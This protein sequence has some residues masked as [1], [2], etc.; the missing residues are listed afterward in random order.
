PCSAKLWYR[1]AAP[2]GIYKEMTSSEVGLDHSFLLTQTDFNSGAPYDFYLEAADQ[3]GNSVHYPTVASNGSDHFT[4]T[5]TGRN[6]STTGFTQLPFTLPSGYILNKTSVI[7]GKPTLV[8]NRYDTSG[9]FGKLMAYQYV[10]GAFNPVDSTQRQWVPRDLKDAFNDGR[11]STLVQ[12]QGVTELLSSNSGGSSFFVNK[13]FVDSADVWGSQLYDFDGDGKL[14]LI[15]RSSSQYLVFKNMGENTFQLMAQLADPTPPLTGETTNEFGPPRSL[16]GDFSGTGNAEIIFADY[17]GDM[18]MYR[19]VNKQTA[20][21]QF[22]L[23]WTDTTDL[24]ETSDYLAAGDF[25]GDGQLDFAIAGHSN[26]D[27]N[28]DRE[29]DPPTWTVRIFTHRPTDP[30]NSFSKVWEQIFYGVK[31]G[32]SYDNGI[33]SGKILGT[34]ADQL[35]LSLN[36]YLYVIQY[37]AAAQNFAPMWVHS[38]ASNSVLVSDFNGDGVPELGFNAD[39]KTRFFEQTSTTSKPQAPWGISATPLSARAV[40]LQ[41]NSVAPSAMHKVYRDTVSQPQNLLTSVVG[42]SFIDT[43]VVTGKTYWYAVSL[44]NPTESDHSSSVSTVPHNPAQIVSVTQ[45]GLSQVS[46]AMSL[47]VD[48]NRLAVAAIVV[49]DSLNPNSIAIHTPSNLLLTFAQP[50]ASDSHYVRI[51]NLFDIYGMD[52]DTTQRIP[53]YASLQATHTFYLESASFVTQS[54]IAIVFNDTLSSSALDVSNYHFS[55][56]VRTFALKDVKLDTVSRSKVLLSLADNEHLTPVGFKMD[57]TA[58][59]KIQNNMGEALNNGEGQSVSLVIDVNNLDNIIV[60]PDPLRFSNVDAGRNHLTF[61]NVPEYCRIDIFETNGRKVTTLEGSTRADGIDWNLMD[62][63]GRP[64][65]SGIYIFLATQLDANNNEVRTKLGKF[66][67]IR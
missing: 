39:G 37:N 40:E 44:V 32:F 30:I 66:A 48:Q 63:H 9:N 61:A 33:S 21:F 20:P 8:L 65:D 64:V 24:L 41:W 6:I 17:D 10:N 31:T 54:L 16:V 5:F 36:P 28:A 38:S 18:I 59:N 3:S 19:Q 34:S 47:P 11:L 4:F 14:D 29:Y 57:L 23:V 42:T 15:A 35:L 27:L 13:T 58:N 7:A 51:K 55:N 60:F 25:N 49:D 12:D 1:T 43:T 62:Q 45:Q 2:A 22:Q 52:A 56:A 50:F 53:F 26:L 46:L 67:I